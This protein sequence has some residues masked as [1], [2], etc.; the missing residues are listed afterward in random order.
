[1]AKSIFRKLPDASVKKRKHVLIVE[2]EPLWQAIIERSLRCI[3]PGVSVITASDAEKA[4]EQLESGTTFDLVISDQRL[5]GP[6][7]G[8]DLWD[9]LLENKTVMPFILVSSADREAFLSSI[10]PYRYR[11]I[12]RYLVKT[13]IVKEFSKE[14][15]RLSVF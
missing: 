7:T 14:I 4:I 15:K 3:H 9:H 1:M 13:N 11:E 2:D 6:R 12:P 10:A 8:L 5:D